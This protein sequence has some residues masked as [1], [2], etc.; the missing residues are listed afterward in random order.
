MSAYIYGAI[1]PAGD[2]GAAIV[3]PRCNTEGTTLHLAEIAAAVA[4]RAHAVR[5]L[6]QAGWHLSVGLVV[7]A[8]IR[9]LPLPPKCP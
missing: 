2:K 6:D 9:L 8:N 4:P 7:P 3:L 5:L 1:C